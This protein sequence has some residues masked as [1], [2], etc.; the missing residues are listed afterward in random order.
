MAM[1]SGRGLP[2]H[3]NPHS[4][5][6]LRSTW[7]C[8]PAASGTA[9]VAAPAG[10]PPPASA[11]VVAVAA[12]AA[13]GAAAVCLR[14]R[15]TLA[16]RRAATKGATGSNIEEGP[17]EPGAEPAE[18]TNRRSQLAAWW[19]KNAKLDRKRLSKMGLMCVLAYG[20]VSNVNAMLL[21]CIS[22]YV[23]MKTTGASPLTS[24][25][26]LRQFGITYGGLY[27]VSNLIRPLRISL[28]LAI[29]P[30]F[31]SFISGLQRRL[32]C[33]RWAAVALT[34][35]LANVLGTFAVL[36]GGL[37]LASIIT[38]VPINLAKFGALVKAGKAARAAG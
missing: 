19:R 32:S 34:V 35:F 29:S 13:G 36:F 10:R 16:A 5:R 22:T 28:A 9:L 21:T 31:E 3:K 38:G 23:A 18:S 11:G 12:A 14:G 26:A 1:A 27:L 25:A 30:A 8:R 33:K 24:A 15:R 37:S 2:R 4:G 17:P 6:V 20:F 7:S